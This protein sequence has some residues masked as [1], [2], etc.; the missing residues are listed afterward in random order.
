MKI[1]RCLLL[2]FALLHG[3]VSGQDYTAIRKQ[4]EGIYFSD[5]QYRTQLDSMV[6]K[7]HLDWNSF[8]VQ[9]LLPLIARQDSVNLIAV[10]D[11][12]NEQ[13]WPGS[14][15]VGACANEAVFLVIQ[16]ATHDVICRYF[17]LL[18]QSCETGGTP[19]RFY[20]MMLDRL[21]VEQKRPQLFGTQISPDV[22]GGVYVPFPIADEAHVDI[23]RAAAGLPDMCSWLNEFNR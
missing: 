19:R 3:I 9:N 16:H 23:R 12:L 1:K 7:E 8:A 22:K 17:P 2:A 4:L 10:S 13:G 11:I 15:L 6:R 20:A 14:E 18:V 21:L 5:Q